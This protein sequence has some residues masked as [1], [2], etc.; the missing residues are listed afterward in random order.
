MKAAT[1][2]DA[3]EAP[4]ELNK[5]VF[6][7]AKDAGQVASAKVANGQAVARLKAVTQIEV[8]AAAEDA[9]RISEAKANESFYVY[10]QW[11]KSHSDIAL[12]GS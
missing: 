7:L 12:G 5:A 10:R 11:A 8:E 3:G 4:A 1:Y 2:N 6:A 9:A